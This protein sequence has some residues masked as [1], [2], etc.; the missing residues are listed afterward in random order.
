MHVRVA[1]LDRQTHHRR[2]RAR[3]VASCSVLRSHAKRG[4]AGR[5]LAASTTVRC[6]HL[7]REVGTAVL[8]PRM[9]RPR[10]LDR[11]STNVGV[12]PRRLRE[13]SGCG[14]RGTRG[15]LSSSRSS[16][17]DLRSWE[18]QAAAL[19]ALIPVCARALRGD[20]DAAQSVHDILVDRLARVVSVL[21]L[22]DNQSPPP[23]TDAETDPG[24]QS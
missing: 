11:A 12:A 18:H 1:Q 14:A 22:I 17:F 7:T 24:V 2:R 23:R 9:P 21:W 16:S 13:P 15:R 10:S 8:R 3:H 5:A 20:G 4:E 6:S 19:S